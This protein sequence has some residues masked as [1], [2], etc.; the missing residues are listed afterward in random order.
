MYFLI[1]HL[2][3]TM[4]LVQSSLHHEVASTLR[5]QIFAGSLAPGSFLDEVALCA[6][7][8]FAFERMVRRPEGDTDLK[9]FVLAAPAP[10]PAAA[11]FHGED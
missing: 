10:V 2:I 9:L 3:A 1:P 6:R 11:A 4:R 5:E 7:L 8:G